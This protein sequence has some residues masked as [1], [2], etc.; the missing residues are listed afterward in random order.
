MKTFHKKD[1]PQGW[2]FADGEVVEV[3]KADMCLIATIGGVQYAMNGLAIMRLKLPEV[4][5]I[6]GRR[7]GPYIKEAMK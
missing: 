3:I 4:N 7:V 6:E 5:I 1:N 2:P